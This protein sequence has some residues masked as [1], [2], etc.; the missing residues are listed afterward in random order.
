MNW[1]KIARVLKKDK[2][3]CYG[4]I[5]SGFSE[6]VNF[7]KIYNDSLE[8]KVY[9][10]EDVLKFKKE[11]RIK[12]NRAQTLLVKDSKV[13]NVNFGELSSA[14]YIEVIKSSRR[15]L[16]EKGGVKMVRKFCKL[17]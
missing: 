8:F 2:I 7:N 9:S 4:I 12:L 10:P 14:D 1:N 15:L 13:R 5:L 3:R 17:R 16:K 11:F 6:M